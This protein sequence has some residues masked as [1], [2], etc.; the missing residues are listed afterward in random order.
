MYLIIIRII[1][2]DNYIKTLHKV[3]SINKHSL[4][5]YLNFINNILDKKK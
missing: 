3:T 1:D 5:Q 4:N 2:N